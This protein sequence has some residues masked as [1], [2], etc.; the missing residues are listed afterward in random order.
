MDYYGP[1]VPILSFRAA[2]IT[3]VIAVTAHSAGAQPAKEP[4]AEAQSPPVV[5]TS[6]LDAELFY[7]IFLGEISSQNGDPGAGY[8]FMLE[9]ARR[10]ADG[11]LYQRAAD[12]ALQA[13]SGEYALAAAK[14]WKNALP[15]SREANRYILQILIAL[16]RV[17]ETGSLLRQEMAQ[18]P[19]WTKVAAL[20]ALPQLYARVSDKAQAA[21]IVEATLAPELAHP[22]TAPS[23]WA[24]VGR[25]RLAAGD[26]PGALDAARKGYA[27]D[28]ASESVSKLLLEMLEDNVREIEPLVAQSLA[29]QPRSELHM[30][31]ARVLLGQQRYPQATQEL[32]LITRKNPALAEPWL[33]LATLKLQENAPEAADKALQ[34]FMDLVA[35][36]PNP[37]IR[38]RGLNQA[39]LLQSQIAE[40][41]GD[42]P[43]AEAALSR[44]DDDAESFGIQTR[45]ALLLARQGKLPQARA[46]LRNLPDTTPEMQKMKLLAE[47][48]LLRELRRFDDAYQV[49]T[50]LVAL[51][52]KDSELLYDQAMLAEKA[53]KPELMEKQLRHIIALDP[54]HHHAYNAL[55]YS[56]ADRGVRLEE[57]KQLIQK[58]MELSPGDPFI[59]DSMGWVEFRMGNKADARRLLESAYQLRADVEIATHL[60]EVLLSMGDKEGAIRVWKEGQKSDPQNETLKDTLR[61]LGVTL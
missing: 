11:R 29:Q 4:T 41:K 44:I 50:E 12:I 28:S 23:V 48:Q 32:E 34:R 15:Q 54:K 20:D 43:A 24:V 16:N 60:G 14:A 33:V 47:V 3:A 10:S 1:M 51:D 55:G 40:K 2:A 38:T 25:M 13:R 37:E 49:Q 6:E 36:I 35:H 5:E 31:Y 7:E 61:R 17:N 26:K 42:F 27:L 21:K 30:A 59:T 57:A 39:Y 9:A 53:G 22:A 52:P 56:Y 19:P 58:A 45:K 8:A 46:L 18:T